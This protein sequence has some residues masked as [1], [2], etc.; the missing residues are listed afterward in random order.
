MNQIKKIDW[1]IAFSAI[2]YGYL[3][4]KQTIGVN[5][6]I[7]TLTQL[8]IISYISTKESR[9]TNWWMVTIGIVLSA[10]SALLYGTL[11]S[12]IGCVFGL[13]LLSAITINKNTSVVIAFFNAIV[14]S[15]FGFILIIK[16][17][18]EIS[19]DKKEEKQHPSIKKN[20]IITLITCFL[21]VVFFSL[22]RQSNAQFKDWTDKIDLSFIS[23]N[24]VVFTLM[25]YYFIYLLYRPFSIQK[26]QEYDINTPNQLKPK[27]NE[28][29]SKYLSITSKLQLGVAIISTLNIVLLLVNAT[30]IVYLFATPSSNIGDYSSQVHQGID[31][32]IFSIILAIA[33]ILYLFGGNINFLTENRR[34]RQLTQFWIIQNCV[35]IGFTALRN[36]EYIEAYFLT[37][38][39]IGVFIYLSCCIVGLVFTYIKISKLKTNWFLVRKVGYTIYFMLMWTPIINWD[40]IIINYNFDRAENN[41]NALDL[42]YLLKLPKVNYPIIE[43][44]I[45]QSSH[46]NLFL[47]QYTNFVEFEEELNSYRVNQKD[48]G[49]QSFN[50]RSSL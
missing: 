7:F 39:R 19:E 33:I 3:F 50:F 4:Y 24:W 6:S 37:Y 29:D 2:L 30:D 45:N 43:K 35:L 9:N 8:F 11:L 18:L 42:T 22:Y 34:L 28:I 15:F 17:K 48:L 21:A 16:S 25:G 32:L 41:P 49:W 46:V 14:S 1:M 5:F 40:S 47:P 36:Y 38:K 27:D 10:M 20:V 26:I 31:A 44:R 13:I 23:F 12:A